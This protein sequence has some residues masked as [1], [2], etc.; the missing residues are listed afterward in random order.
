MSTISLVLYILF[1]TSGLIAIKLG[2]EK[3]TF[4]EVVGG[5]VSIN[6]N[7]FLLL[8]ILFYG[9]SFFLFTYL[10]AKNDLGYIIPL[11]TAIVY[12]LI[13]IASFLIFKETFTPL[14]IVAI[15]MI[16]LGVILLNLNK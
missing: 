12:I 7:P 1:S 14:K 2:S 10:V 11:T 6:T 13:F 8:G 15:T 4:L 3:S 5:K 9:I 16:I